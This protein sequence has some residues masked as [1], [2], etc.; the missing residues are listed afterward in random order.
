MTTSTVE[1]APFSTS[2]KASPTAVGVPAVTVRPAPGCWP[3]AASG[4]LSSSRTCR[5]GQV[6]AGATVHF[7]NIRSRVVG[8]EEGRALCP[9]TITAV[10]TTARAI[11]LA[12]DLVFVFGD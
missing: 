6:P 2:A 7:T 12:V 1:P 10:I 3:S 9:N 8:V 4:R 5:G 11:G